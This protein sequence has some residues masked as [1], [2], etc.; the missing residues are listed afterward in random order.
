MISTIT[1]KGQATIPLAVRRHLG[2][3]PGDKVDF[4]IEEDGAVVVR[5][6]RYPT[7]AS[8]SGAAGK[9]GRKLSKQE[10]LDIAHEDAAIEKYGE[11]R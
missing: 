8:L 6:V 5:P 9:L 4:V 11:S 7:I 10:M 1:T 2:L 3:N